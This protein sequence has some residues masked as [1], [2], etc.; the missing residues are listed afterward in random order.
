MYPKP[1]VG[2]EED[3][4]SDKS[5]QRGPTESNWISSVHDWRQPPAFEVKWNLQEANLRYELHISR[6]FFGPIDRIA[7]NATGERKLNALPIRYFAYGSNMHGDEMVKA[8]GRF[9]KIGVARL[10]DYRLA[11]T[12]R[13]KCWGA[14]VA[15][16][17]ESKR[18][19]VWGVLYSIDEVALSGLDHKEGY[20]GPDANDN[21]YVRQ[22]VTVCLAGG[23]QFQALTYV[24]TEKLKDELAPNPEYLERL[25]SGALQNNLDKD[26]IAF[27]QAIGQET[28]SDFRRGVLVKPTT[29]RQGA[30]GTPIIRVSEQV[31]QF[32]QGRL[33][34][35]EYGK[36]TALAVTIR[37]GD[38]AANECE[39]DQSI[40]TSLAAK[41][42]FTFGF[43]VRLSQ[44]DEHPNH[45]LVFQPRTL[46]LPLHRPSILDSEKNICILHSKNIALM[47]VQEGS[48]V[49]ITAA[50]RTPTGRY[51]VRKIT[52]RVFSGSDAKL[53]Q[54]ENE[55]LPYPTA[56]K[57]Y[58][59]LDG[60][61]ALGLSRDDDAA[62]VLINPT[63]SRVFLENI[64][65][66]G[67]TLLVGLLAIQP[68]V[69][70]LRTTMCWSPITGA[71]LTGTF[72]IGM[73]CVL[74]IFDL[75][76][77]VHY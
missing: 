28:D 38:V 69:D 50:G 19:S 30:R 62:P 68:L 44:T 3:G 7:Q 59:D 22:W 25:V 76:S 63:M 40:R 8:G 57:L 10:D 71:L 75:R 53:H 54:P 55:E 17:V 47:G 41:S 61:L 6:L 20:K 15:D 23:P 31:G 70:V 46:A 52:R 26:Y 36:R 34:A 18:L 60:R 64:M 74:T 12:R 49:T 67:I 27:L 5:A 66:Y 39:L 72:A 51:V 32:K 9:E 1:T 37:C 21:A 77:R 24:V 16:V 43:F 35:I 14:G 73:T 58:L 29:T 65:R 11:F 4:R 45:W 33:C 56:Q 42:R 48:Y 13:S 2:I